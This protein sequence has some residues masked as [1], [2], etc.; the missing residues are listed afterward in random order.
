MGGRLT[1]DT[2]TEEMLPALVLSRGLYPAAS[3]PLSG[4][5]AGITAEEG[6]KE[7]STTRSSSFCFLLFFYVFSAGS[8][9]ARK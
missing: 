5:A 4:I 8:R 1:G 6:F 2:C 7:G 3:G 9:A